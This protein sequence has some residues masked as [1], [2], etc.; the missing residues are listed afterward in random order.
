MDFGNIVFYFMSE[1]LAV[2]NLAL[3]DGGKY[4]PFS[5]GD[6]LGMAGT[7]LD[8]PNVDWIDM[9]D[10]CH[11]RWDFLSPLVDLDPNSYGLDGP[12]K[13]DKP[14]KGWLKPKQNNG[15]FT[16]Y[17]LVQDFATIHSMSWKAAAI[18]QR[19]KLRCSMKVRW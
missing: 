15:M 13:S 18:I 7:A 17:Q 11:L 12:A 5:N 8:L 19:T 10:S 6:D 2:R 16:T 3:G 1:S 4:H 14:P 9:D